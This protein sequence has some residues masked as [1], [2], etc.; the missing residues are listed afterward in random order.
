MKSFALMKS[1]YFEVQLV[2]FKVPSQIQTYG[3]TV[4]PEGTQ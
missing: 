2:S 1:D 4:P 3:I